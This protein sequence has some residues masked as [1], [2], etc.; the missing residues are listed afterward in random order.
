MAEN[1]APPAPN[2]E[3]HCDP[4][5]TAASRAMSM[6]PRR[7]RTGITEHRAR[8]DRWLVSYAD[9]IT[10]LFAFFVVMYAMST[11][12]EQRYRALSESLNA[13]FGSAPMRET[14]TPTTRV[15][16]EEARLLARERHLRDLANGLEAILRPLDEQGVVHIS[17]SAFGV[18][19]EIGASALFAPAEAALE[20]EAREVLRAVA[21][22]LASS[23]HPLR[24]EG[25]TDALPI[26]TAVYPSNWE[27]S[28]ARASTV[29]RLFVE[30]GVAPGRIGVMG[31]ADNR[32][33]ADN[34]T[35]AGRMRNR[36]VTLLILAEEPADMAMAFGP[37]M[38][39]SECADLSG[40]STC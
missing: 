5:D 30:Q 35:P 13:A 21:A 22:V 39:R 25:H 12:N 23:P 9:F 2:P 32:P 31:Y 18:T 27:L 7:T 10:L 11:V 17:Q 38:Y 26:S 28:A 24:I 33:V 4:L 8:R 1:E 34:S 6:P 20:T 36:R 16:A 40:P 19:V 37:S 14:A 29:A 3:A 15:T